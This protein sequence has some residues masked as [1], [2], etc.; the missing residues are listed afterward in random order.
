MFYFLLLVIFLLGLS[1]GSFLNCLLWR[2][3]KEEKITGRSKCPK[4]QHQISWRDNIPLLSFFLLKGKCRHCHE[5]ISW[6]YPLGELVVGLL[7]LGVFLALF[8]WPSSYAEFLSSLG[9]NE[10]YW[11]LKGWL[12]VFFMVAIFIFD[13]RWLEISIPLILVAA[14][15]FLGLNFLLGVSFLDSAL[16]LAVGA[17]FFF[18]QYVFTKGR[19]IGEGDIWLGGLMGLIFPSLELLAVALFLSYMSGSIF[20]LFLL[21][22][23]KKA[24]RKTK[25]PL[26]V[27][28]ALGSLLTWFWGNELLAW[29][30]GLLGR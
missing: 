14:F 24:G 27:F 16:A 26:G 8:S 11:L 23:D 13:L 22:I 2:L 7:F 28:L 10:I 5:K 19:G 1:L 4:C 30:L 17:L 9:P 29:Y 12:V 15:L 18:I 3:Y 21:I 6:Q 20:S 25:L